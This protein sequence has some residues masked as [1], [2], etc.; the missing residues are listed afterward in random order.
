LYGAQCITC[1]NLTGDGVGGIDLRR[2]TFR[3]VSS[4][5]DLRHTITGGVPGTAMPKFDVTPAEQNALVAYIRSGFE[6][7]GRAVKV[8]DVARGK[9]VYDKGGCASCHR[10]AGAGSRKAPDLTDIGSMRSASMLQQSIVDPTAYLLPINRPVRVVTRD[11]KTINGRRLNEDTYTVQLI[12]EN[13]RLLS[14]SKAD[15]KEFH[16]L[17]TSPM[18][19]FRDK[20]SPEEIADMVAYLLSLKG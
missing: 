4:D 8:G 12:D 3:R 17:T 10:A 13:E 16:V 2:G 19:S 9:A 14:L 1:H 11:G 5:E 15:L 7:G 18:P 6:V 20:L